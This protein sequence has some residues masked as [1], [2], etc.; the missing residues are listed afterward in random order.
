EQ[1][2]TSKKIVH[3]IEQLK[4]R[5]Q[6]TYEKFKECLILAKREDLK[7]TLEEEE[8]KVAAEMK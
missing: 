5:D 2:T 1:R 6:A 7:K 4:Q 8:K 3:L